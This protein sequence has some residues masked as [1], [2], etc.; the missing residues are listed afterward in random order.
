MITNNISSD[1]FKEKIKEKFLQGN[2]KGPGASF[3]IKIFDKVS[4]I[5]PLGGETSV[6][7]IR[8]RTNI[9]TMAPN[10]LIKSISVILTALAERTRNMTEILK[11]K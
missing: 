9:P 7:T 5:L 6:L 1:T 11:I 4:V 3:L 2:I 8:N 10:L